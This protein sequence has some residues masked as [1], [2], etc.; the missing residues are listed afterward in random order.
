[1]KNKNPPEGGF[2]RRYFFSRVARFVIEF[3]YYILARRPLKSNGGPAGI[4]QLAED[5]GSTDVKPVFV[6]VSN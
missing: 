3:D 6:T 1:M 5:P 2:L 4:R